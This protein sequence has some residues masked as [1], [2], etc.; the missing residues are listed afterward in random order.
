ML[1][2]YYV[3]SLKDKTPTA[4]GNEKSCNQKLWLVTLPFRLL[5]TS[6]NFAAHGLLS[7]CPDER[8]N[9][10]PTCESDAFLTGDLSP[11]SFTLSCASAVAD[12]MVAMLVR[13][14]ETSH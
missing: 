6:I 10:P 8:T 1:N 9:G 14:V 4:Q 13:L 7:A 12:L 2:S 5:L 11:H 3:E